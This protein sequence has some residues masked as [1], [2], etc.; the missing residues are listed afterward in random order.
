[1]TVDYSVGHAN[2]ALYR[3]Q[4]L[5]RKEKPPYDLLISQQYRQHLDV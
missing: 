1:M 4:I 3:A 5:L 2:E